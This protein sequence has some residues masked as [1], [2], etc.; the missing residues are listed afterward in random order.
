V[1]II[2][3][4]CSSKGSF[5]ILFWMMLLKEYPKEEGWKAINYLGKEKVLDGF[6]SA[7]FQ[8]CWSIVKEW[9]WVHLWSSTPKVFLRKA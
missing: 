9:L 4:G 1:R 6:N 3:G 7:F 2:W 8:H 5:G